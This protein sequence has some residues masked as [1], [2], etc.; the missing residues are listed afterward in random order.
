MA[1]SIA[2]PTAVQWMGLL[3]PTPRHHPD[4]LFRLLLVDIDHVHPLPDA[5]M[6]C[7]RDFSDQGPEMGAGAVSQI[8]LLD[9]AAPKVRQP[10]AETEFTVLSAL[11][12]TMPFQHHQ[13][14]VRRALSQLER[15]DNFGHRH[16]RAAGGEK[17]QHR[18]GAVE[19]L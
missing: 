18:K 16:W 5:Q 15:V 6:G 8:V 1:A 14:A 12:H 17:I 9:R 2:L 13:K 7:L 4:A 11:H 3:A 10:Q 19:R